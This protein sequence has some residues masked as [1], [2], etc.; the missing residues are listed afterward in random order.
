MGIITETEG[1]FAGW[2]TWPDEIFE[3]ESAGPFYFKK[4]DGEWVSRFRAARKHMN[5]GNV[6]HGGCLMAFADF[7]LFAIAADDMPEGGYGATVAF[8]CEFIQGPVIGDLM[9]ARGEVIRAG[10]SI[11][12]VRGQVTAEGKIALNFSG[13]IKKFK[14]RS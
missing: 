13:T 7:A 12:F 11:I 4:I 1:E 5:A 6:M 14:P 3:Y 10:S 9:E 8:N 2:L